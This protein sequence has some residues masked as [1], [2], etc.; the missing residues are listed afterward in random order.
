MHP[1]LSGVDGGQC[2]RSR[3]HPHIGHRTCPY[4]IQDQDGGAGRVAP[5]R[6]RRDFDGRGGREP[7]LVGVVPRLTLGKPGPPAIVVAPD[8]DVVGVVEGPGA[9]IEYR[10][11]S[12]P[13]WE[14]KRPD[15][16]G[17]AAPAYIGA[18]A[19][20]VGGVIELVPPGKFYRGK[21]GMRP[22]C[23]RPIG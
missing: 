13:S 23:W 2:R 15:E 6:D 3:G 20:A 4:R 11:S 10:V 7:P 1:A 5:P 16:P 14:G 21:R 19:L 8:R 18:E 17:E 9:P 12:G 22:D